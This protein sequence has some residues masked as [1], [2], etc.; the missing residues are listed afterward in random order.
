[1]SASASGRSSTATGYD[2]KTEVKGTPIIKEDTNPSNVD[3]FAGS[4]GALVDSSLGVIGTISGSLDTSVVTK[5][6]EY[7]PTKE[8]LYI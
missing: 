5:E 4:V 3:N 8:Y 2:Y 7:L 6:E 1:G